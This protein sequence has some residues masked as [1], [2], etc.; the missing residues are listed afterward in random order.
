MVIQYGLLTG[1]ISI[2]I[3]NMKRRELYGGDINSLL[4]FLS[5]SVWKE[6]NL[7]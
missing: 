3:L 2:G 4:I 6:V 5:Y 7:S 1:R